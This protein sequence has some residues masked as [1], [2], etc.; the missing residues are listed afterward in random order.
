M[1]RSDRWAY[2]RALL[3]YLLTRQTPRGLPVVCGDVLL[4]EFVDEISTRQAVHS[5]SVEGLRAWA[6]G[7]S[8]EHG[9]S[10]HCLCFMVWQSYRVLV[11][12]HAFAYHPDWLCVEPGPQWG[13]PDFP[14]WTRAGRR[15]V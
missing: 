2:E 9:D 14:A 8:E 6:F 10:P 1:N 5:A 11:G 12:A 13:H 15:V 4:A 3:R 7:R